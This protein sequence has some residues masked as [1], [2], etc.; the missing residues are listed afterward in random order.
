LRIHLPGVYYGW[1]VVGAAFLIAMYVGGALFYGFTAIFEPIANDFGWSYAQ[2]S[3]AASLRGLEM[4]LLAFPAGI[5]VDRWGPRKLAFGGSL[6]TAGGLVLLYYSASLVMFYGAFIIIAIGMSTTAMT[7]LMAAINNWFRRK[8]GLASGIAVS[9][10]ACGG[11]LIPLITWLIELYDWRTTIIILA[12]GMLGLVAPLS[13]LLRNRPAQPATV[14]T[15][16]AGRKGPLGGM[17]HTA[18][19]SPNMGVKQALRS[20]EFWLITLALTIHMA[21]MSSVVTH[22][23][24]YLHS[25]NITGAKSSMAAA[26]VPLLSIGGRLGLGWLGDRLQCQRVMAAAFLAVALGMLCLEYLTAMRIWILIPFLLLF[27]TGYGG[28]MGLRPSLVRGFCNPK[29]FGSIFG[30]LLSIS[31]LGAVAGPVI[32]GWAFDNWQSYQGVWLIFAGMA[33]IAM[34]IFLAAPLA[35]E[36][37]PGDYLSSATW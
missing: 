7:V 18:T 37:A 3:L 4:S 16:E 25:I 2:V 8:I 36:N 27:S 20:R 29:R 17:S 23:M 11:L 35:K 10:F 26:A 6:I 34:V 19:V 13:L 1:F 28:I 15:S 9:G 30:L 22:I 14:L 33:I 32:A 12:L 24:P 21:I 5:L 31:M